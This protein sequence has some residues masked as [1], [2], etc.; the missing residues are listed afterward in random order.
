MNMKYSIVTIAVLSMAMSG[1]GRDGQEAAQASKTAAEA[2]SALAERQIEKAGMTLDDAAVTARV[3]TALVVAPDLKGLAINVDTLG[4]VV[5]LSGTVASE[6]VRQQAEA[7]A[8]GVDGVKGV[9]NNLMVK[10]PS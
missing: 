6:G 2:V 8:K 10:Q 1:C 5:T 9:T 7:M 4:N 3:K